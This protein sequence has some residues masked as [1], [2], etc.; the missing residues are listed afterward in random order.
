MKHDLIREDIGLGKLRATIDALEKFELDIKEALCYG[1]GSHNFTDVVARVLTGT[2]D[3]YVFPNSVIIMEFTKYPNHSVYHGYIAAGD[4]QEIL[5]AHP[6][7][8]KEARARKCKYLTIAGRKGW[9]RPMK[10]HGWQHS[11]SVMQK[12]VSY[13]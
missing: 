5:D 11:L 10:L 1:T 3:L 7:I 12:E 9:E 8:E 4:L 13:E 6:M 2:L